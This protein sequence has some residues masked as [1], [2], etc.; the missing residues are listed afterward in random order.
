MSEKIQSTFDDREK[1]EREELMQSEAFK[2]ATPLQKT[3]FLMALRIK[4][5]L[6]L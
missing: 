6:R 2:N 5:A 1:K 3:E 4:N